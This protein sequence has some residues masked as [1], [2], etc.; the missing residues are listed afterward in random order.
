MIFF[1]I[2]NTTVF[3]LISSYNYCPNIKIPNMKKFIFLLFSLVISYHNLSALT[4]YNESG[5]KLD[6]SL[7]K[8]KT[9][10]VASLKRNVIIW[11]SVFELNNNNKKAIAI[12]IPC[13]LSYTYAYLNPAEISTVQTYVPDIKLS[14]VYK[15]YVAQKPIMVNSKQ[16]I[17]S[18]KYFAT[19]DN[20]DLRTATVNWD[21]KFSFWV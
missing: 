9:I 14:D 13:Y 7:V 21:F 17:I 20:V 4:F 16:T 5:I 6:H 1:F 19:M 2:N 3:E 15:N 8:Q 12:R 11:K 10:Y 18:E